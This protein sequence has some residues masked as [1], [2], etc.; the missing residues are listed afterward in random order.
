M[1]NRTIVSVGVGL[2]GMLMT[3]VACSSG[4]DSAGE[5]A[6]ADTQSP[7]QMQ[8]GQP[9]SSAATV[10]SAAP[11]PECTTNAE[12]KG[13]GP[14]NFCTAPACEGGR[15]VQKLLQPAGTPLPSQR[16]GDCIERRC[17][18]SGDI[19]DVP[20]DGDAFN[21]GNECTDDTCKNGVRV[22]TNKAQGYLCTYGLCTAAGSCVQCIPGVQP[23]TVQGQICID[24]F[25]AGPA[26]QN[27]VKDVGEG[28]V[29]CGG[30]CPKC[31]AGK[32]C[33]TGAQCASGTCSNGLCANPT[34]SDNLKNGDETATDCGGSCGPCP[35][36]GGCKSHA[37]CQSMNCEDNFC[38][39]PS[40]TDAVKNGDEVGVDC[41]G[42]C[43]PCP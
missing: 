35:T 29:D 10:P 3:L 2:F 24:G 17:G 1:R 18:E 9:A 30:A 28:D 5:G 6:P 21:D 36:D 8:P 7:E 20:L 25:C 22:S 23:C 14:S 4:P 31:R 40:C 13:S 41:G 43:V 15:C 19:V 37:D 39:A 12:C 11:A 32:K 34:C 16:Y 27:G 42:S 38:I 26:C 33:T